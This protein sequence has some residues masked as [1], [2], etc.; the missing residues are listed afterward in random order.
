MNFIDEF[1]MDKA[2]RTKKNYKWILNQYFTEIKQ[3]SNTYF[4]KD[5]D[6]QADVI[7]WWH[8]HLDEVP[9][10]RNTKLAIVKGFLEEYE[11]IFPKKFWLKLRRKRKGSR[12]STLDRVPTKSEFKSILI[13]G[14]V[15]DKALFLFTMSSGMRIDE[16]LKLKPSMIDLNH[17]PPIVKIPATISKTGN[18]RITFITPETKNYLL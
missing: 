12:A 2:E 6:Y 14:D 13:H 8:N 1:L 10:T 15:K 5:R 3:D 16:V 11:I 7:N 18:P 17:D 4:K 9:K